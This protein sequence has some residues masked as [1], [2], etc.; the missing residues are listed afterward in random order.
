MPMAH[1][2]NNESNTT[3]R[4]SSYENKLCAAACKAG[5]VRLGG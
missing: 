1:I 5:P 2:A 3:A 4:D